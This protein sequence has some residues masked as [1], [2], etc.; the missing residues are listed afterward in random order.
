MFFGFFGKAKLPPLTT[1][2]L[3]LSAHEAL[4]EFADNMTM[5]SSSVI[6]RRAVV[7]CSVIM[8][9]AGHFVGGLR[10][11]REGGWEESQRYLRDTNLDVITAEAMVWIQFLMGKHGIADQKK[12]HE[13]FIERVGSSTFTQAARLVF[14]VIEKQTGFDFE[15]T[16]GERRKFYHEAM[17][18]GAIF[19]AF[20]TVVFRS[21]GRRSLADPLKTIGPLPRLEWTPV[22]HYVA[23]FFSTVPAASYEMFKNILRRWPDRFADD[24][25]L[26]DDSC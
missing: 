17:N 7:L 20:A 11:G 24:D 23:I 9:A 13:T 19:E 6:N 22:A 8:S 26:E 1:S 3:K 10:W 4:Q 2:C 12:D 14:D 16:A 25:D 18:D 21:V 5:R 15:V